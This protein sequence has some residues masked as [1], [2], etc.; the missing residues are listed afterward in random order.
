MVASIALV[1]VGALSIPLSAVH[2]QDAETASPS[3]D[4]KPLPTPP[5]RSLRTNQPPKGP[6][7]VAPTLFSGYPDAPPFTVFPQKDKIALYPCSQCHSVLPPNKE[8][9]ALVA[10][11]HVADLPHGNG[12]M[13]CLTC[14]K[15]DDR[16][17]LVTL[18]GDPVDF[19]DAHLVCGQ[20]HGLRHREWHFGAHGKRV[21]NWKGERVLF[22][23]THCHDPHTP[24]LQPRKPSKPP[25]VRAGLQ[26]MQRSPHAPADAMEHPN[27]KDTP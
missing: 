27:P 24:A 16:D 14:H 21:G 10:A 22:N 11:P 3:A 2:A 23:C 18:A 8:P 19:D 1:L 9:R 6:D 12:R 4:Q 17:V 5:H 25:A 20:C 26:P 7:P 13:W 15:L